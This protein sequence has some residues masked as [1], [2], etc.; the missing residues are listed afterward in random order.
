MPLVV[1]DDDIGLLPLRELLDDGAAVADQQRRYRHRACP[2]GLSLQV[3]AALV[4]RHDSDSGPASAAIC[5]AT[6]WKSREPWIIT[7]TGP[8]PIVA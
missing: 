6:R 5:R 8:E 1:A 4:D 3:V 7:M 2:A